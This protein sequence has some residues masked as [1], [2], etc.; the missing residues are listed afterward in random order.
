MTLSS[1]SAVCG[2]GIS[3]SFKSILRC[4]Y[5]Q[6]VGNHDKVI[7][8]YFNL[9]SDLIFF[10]ILVLWEFWIL[11]ESRITLK[12]VLA[13]VRIIVISISSHEQ[14]YKTE[15]VVF[16]YGRFSPSIKNPF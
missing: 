7:S 16:K 4:V 9:K 8:G 12:L 2:S 15:S 10:H 13:G 1:W 6:N 14:L 11:S 3:W 5:S